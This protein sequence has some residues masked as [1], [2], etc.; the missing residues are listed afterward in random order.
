MLLAGRVKN[1]ISATIAAQDVDIPVSTVKINS[2][3]TIEVVARKADL[4][5]ALKSWNMI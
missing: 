3:A 1:R 4:M 2:L 5:P